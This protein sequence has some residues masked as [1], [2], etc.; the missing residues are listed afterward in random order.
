MKT[1]VKINKGLWGKKFITARSCYYL[2]G[3]KGQWQQAMLPRRWLF[4]ENQGHKVRD[5]LIGARKPR[6]DAAIAGET[7]GG[8]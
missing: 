7:R 4:R 6:E 3:V 1:A 8:R 2:Y 5:F